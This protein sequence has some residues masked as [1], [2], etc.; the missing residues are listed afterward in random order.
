MRAVAAAHPNVAL[1]KYWG[2]AD[3]TRNIPAVGSL[4]I[5]LGGLTTRTEVEFDASRETDALLI[6]DQVDR[7]GTAKALACLDALRQLAGCD[8]RAV[9]RSHN[10]FPTGAGLAS[11]ASGFAALT[12]AAAAA[13]ELDLRIDQ[14]AEI[15]RLGS[16]SAPRSLYG[17]YVLLEVDN[18]KTGTRCGTILDAADWPLHVVVAVTSS[19]QKSVGSTEGMESSRLTSPY[20]PAWVESHADDLRT[21]LDCLERRD[22]QQLA[23]VSE[24]SCL[25]MHALAM[26]ASP[27]LL[28]WSGATLECMHAIRAMREAGMPVFF[29]VDAGPQVKAVCLPEIA[30]KVRE[31]LA[32]L[33]GVLQV[34]D[35]T[36]GEG[37]RVE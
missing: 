25:K 24:R 35:S 7:R 5:T 31:R 18:Q 20:Y 36:L 10:D 13:L 1:I 23:E 33:P 4:S 15:A 17:G 34:I 11:S 6:N 16:G 30:P 21:G 14:L 29:T 12:R 37:A 9:V 27:G 26:S 8:H 22:F 28:Y 3:Q 32:G 2:K 19:E